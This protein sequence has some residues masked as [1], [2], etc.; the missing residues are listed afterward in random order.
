MRFEPKLQVATGKEL[1]MFMKDQCR[2]ISDR[3]IDS[4]VF[5]L[6]QEPNPLVMWH[7]LSM[8]ASPGEEL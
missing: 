3:V 1:I 8:M 4:S 6:E 5:E 7:I 2:R